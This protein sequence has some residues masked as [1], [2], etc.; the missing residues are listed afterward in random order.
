MS[1]LVY[2]TATSVNGYVADENR[3][4]S[5]EGRNPTAPTI[6]TGGDVWRLWLEMEPK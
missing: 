6:E 2:S 5:R 4:V 3:A 1:T